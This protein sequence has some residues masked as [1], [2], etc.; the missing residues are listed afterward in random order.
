MNKKILAISALMLLASAAKD[1]VSQEKNEECIRN[2]S[3]YKSLMDVEAYT[4]AEEP[5]KVL[6]YNYP[7]YSKQMYIDGVKIYKGL[8]A[9]ASNTELA[10]GY[11]DT[12]KAI[13]LQRIQYFGDSAN[14]Y[15]RCGLDIMK[16]RKSDT[17]YLEAFNLLD[18]AVKISNYNPDLSV[19]SAHLQL[20][21]NLAASKKI[22][23]D[24]FYYSAVPLLNSI[25]ANILSGDKDA[26]YTKSAE[27][28]FA[29]IKNS[30]AKLNS[31]LLAET[32]DKLTPQAEIDT[33]AKVIC[34][35]LANLNCDNSDTY[36][37]A[38]EKLYAI[39]PTAEAAAA[40]ALY[41]KKKQDWEKTSQ[42]FKEA[43]E[44]ETD[45]HKQADY[46]YELASSSSQ[47]KRYAEAV[48]FAKKSVER[49]ESLA[50]AYLLIAAIYG[51]NAPTLAND[52]FER[53]KIYW[54]A[55]DYALKAKRADYNL[56]DEAESL[57][58]KYAHQFP[59]REEAFMHS[60]QGGQQVE[61]EILKNKETTSA[62]F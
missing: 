7:Q 55:A 42:Y 53:G 24:R 59:S 21:T 39:N 40:I 4:Y 45:S 19:A 12:I 49:N 37:K 5:F 1:A 25:Y 50:K 8:Y 57:I 41:Y 46:Y 18:K 44:K 3:L 61:V 2:H 56:K 30:S 15:G 9:K 33:F 13:Y 58:N 17:A 47:R 23:M 27:S 51:A 62:R 35:T 52:V 36:A 34:K 26:A 6:F 28:I 31:K 60:I 32:V 10:N 20:A 54:V 48:A 16:L 29:S 22:D 43:V 14:V 11:T 38:S